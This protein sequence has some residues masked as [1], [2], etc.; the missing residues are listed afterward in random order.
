MSLRYDRSRRSGPSGREQRPF[1]AERRHAN[2][3]A[4]K[5]H[6]RAEQS[7]Q[8]FLSVVVPAKN[9][10]TSLP[11]LVHEIAC[12]LRPLCEHNQ[13]ELVGFEIIVVDDGS[14]DLT[15]LVL[16][17]LAAAYPELKR[18]ALRESVG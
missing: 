5:S 14:T 1:D 8:S 4:P 11:Q 2:Q 6:L 10:A 13:R 17:D 3:E 18:L 9:E 12:A 7:T 16:Q 15:Q